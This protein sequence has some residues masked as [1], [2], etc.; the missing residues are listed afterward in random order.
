MSKSNPVSEAVLHLAEQA[1][2]SLHYVDGYWEVWVYGATEQ[3]ARRYSGKTFDALYYAGYID[4][5][6]HSMSH[7][8]YYL[9]DKGWTFA[10][11]LA[12]M[13]YDR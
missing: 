3:S 7:H 13:R 1:L 9:T 2:S 10:R 12:R 6:N 11:E 8:V 4:S 5:P